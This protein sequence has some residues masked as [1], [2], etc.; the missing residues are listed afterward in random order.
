[1]ILMTVRALI[2][3][4]A[5]EKSRLFAHLNSVMRAIVY[6]TGVTAIVQ[7]IL[8]AVGFAIVGLP[9]PIVFGAMATLFAL[10]PLVGTPV[11]WVP[12]VAVLAIQQRWVAA[13]FLLAWG[14]I[15][16]TLDNFLRPYLVSGRAEVHTITVFIGVFGGAL[17]FG[18]LGLFL[19]PLLLALAIA[20]V[21]FTLDVRSAESA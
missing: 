14:V 12:A 18:A 15:V 10:L 6:G 20:L 19:G 5:A 7:G 9:S 3:M 2:P 21:R 1:V 17:A 13:G 8:I 16:A 11:V 4:S